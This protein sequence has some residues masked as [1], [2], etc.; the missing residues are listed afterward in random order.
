MALV[1]AKNEQINTGNFSDTRNSRPDLLY[2]K[3]LIGFVHHSFQW[4]EDCS[5][6]AMLTRCLLE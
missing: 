5:S 1:V 3:C 2:L 6:Q 4:S